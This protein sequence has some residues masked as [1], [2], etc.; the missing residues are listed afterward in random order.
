METLR[1]ILLIL[2]I[3]WVGVDRRAFGNFQLHQPLIAST[4]SGL[5]VGL[6]EMGCLMGVALQAV[7][8]QPLTLGGVI[9]LATGPAACAGILWLRT[10][11]PAGSGWLG[12]GSPLDLLKVVAPLPLII[13]WVAVLG[14]FLEGKI[15]K[16]NWRLEN[17]EGDRSGTR[18]HPGFR[19]TAIGLALPG[20]AAILAVIG[21][22]GPIL[23]IRLLIGGK[24]PAVSVISDLPSMEGGLLPIY[25]WVLLGIGLGGE[26]GRLIRSQPRGWGWIAAGILGGLVIGWVLS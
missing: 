4:V 22:V 24:E 26:V 18:G 11:L 14:V 8:L 20:L 10:I 13:L 12:D 9:P 19:I 21:S 1:W 6:P 16:I 23:L 15:R 25:L 5:I 3:F 7:W 17:E 2:W